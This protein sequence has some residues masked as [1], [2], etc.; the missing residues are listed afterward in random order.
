MILEMAQRILGIQCRRCRGG[1]LTA[2]CPHK[3]RLPEVT[4][5]P[6]QITSTFR[7]LCIELSSFVYT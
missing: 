7:F 5:R 3:D 2:K 6:V 4:E 1:H